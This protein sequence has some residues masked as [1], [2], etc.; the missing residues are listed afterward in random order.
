MSSQEF[1]GQEESLFQ[2]L[3]SML[4][5]S[6]SVQIDNA[7]TVW[8]E[9]KKY[10][11]HA[12]FAPMEKVS[13]LKEVNVRASAS[14][15][16]VLPSAGV[17]AAHADFCKALSDAVLQA[18]GADRA[19]FEGVFPPSVLL[20]FNEETRLYQAID[21]ESKPLWEVTGDYA[22]ILKAAELQNARWAG[23]NARDLFIA[24]KSRDVDHWKA[25]HGAMKLQRDHHRN[26]STALRKMYLSNIELLQEV[27]EVI[28]TEPDLVP[29]THRIHSAVQ[30][31]AR[32][33]LSGDALALKGMGAN[34]PWMTSDEAMQVKRYNFD[35]FGDEHVDEWGPYVKAYDFDALAAQLIHQGEIPPVVAVVYQDLRGNAVLKFPHEPAPTSLGYGRVR[36][37]ELRCSSHSVEAL[38]TRLTT[39]EGLLASADE[40]IRGCVSGEVPVG[41]SSAKIQ[42]FN[43]DY[44]AAQQLAEKE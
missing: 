19:A 7:R 29:L 12:Q 26:V 20:E 22:S 6:A 38:T 25:L 43:E 16:A 27:A 1:Q 14:S 40:I 23:W 4:G 11:V 33:M 34:M 3:M 36:K 9:A 28:R 18:S 41:A 39:Y 44:Q 17:K 32:G 10:A 35:R 30:E 37:V 8:T 13:I 31:G 24:E 21:P 5:L 15:E 42:K 2:S